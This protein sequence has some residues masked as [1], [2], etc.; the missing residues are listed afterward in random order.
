L[1]AEPDEHRV[2]RM[3]AYLARGLSAAE[4][5]RVVLRADAV[6]PAAEGRGLAGGAV[7]LA[8]SLDAF[9]EPAAQAVLDRLLADFTAETVLGQV[10][11]PYLRNL[12][13]R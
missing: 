10:I 5:A 9:D 2:R 7:A 11:L 6:S 3:Q 1:Y 13:D 4:A 8:A 12:G